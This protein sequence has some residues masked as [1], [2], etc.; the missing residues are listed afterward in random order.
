MRPRAL[1]ARPSAVVACV[2]L[3]G[4]AAVPAEGDADHAEFMTLAIDGD[5]GLARA[6]TAHR[7]WLEVEALRR[8]IARAFHTDRRPMF[9]AERVARVSKPRTTGRIRCDGG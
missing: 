2:L 9:F 4:W 8:G 3:G 1:V 6:W 7:A 5:A